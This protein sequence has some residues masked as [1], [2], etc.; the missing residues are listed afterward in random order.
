ME[1]DWEEKIS[2][3]IWKRNPQRK[4]DMVRYNTKGEEKYY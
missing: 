4:I 2:L 3:E 1:T